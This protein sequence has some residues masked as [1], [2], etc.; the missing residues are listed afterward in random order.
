MVAWPSP[1]KR[2]AQVG[3][4][5]LAPLHSAAQKWRPRTRII[6][7]AVVSEVFLRCPYVDRPVSKG[8]NQ[9][10]KRTRSVDYIY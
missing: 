1:L 5:R 6:E 10:T 8:A 3:L 4:H 9:F 7:G 2:D